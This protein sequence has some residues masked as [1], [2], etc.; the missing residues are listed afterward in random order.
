MI[1]EKTEP[2]S[3]HAAVGVAFD[4]GVALF[5]GVAFL[6]SD[7]GFFTIF[8]FFEAGLL[9]AAGPLVTRPDFVFPRTVFVSTIAGA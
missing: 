9:A 4:L 1:T 7:A 5:L 8:D 2:M 3:S 6:A